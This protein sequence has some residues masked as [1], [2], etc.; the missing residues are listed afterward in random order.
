MFD[1][2]IMIENYKCF[3][4][5]AGFDKICRMNFIVGRN[6][7]G[8]SS[9]LDLA[10]FSCIGGESFG[11]Q[12]PIGKAEPVIKY[13]AHLTQR[14]IAQVF[15]SSM[16][17][18]FYYGTHLEYGMKLVG[19]RVEVSA[20]LKDGGVYRCISWADDADDDINPKLI[21]IPEDLKARLTALIDSPLRGK[22]FK[23]ILAERDVRPEIGG[24]EIK[25]NGDGTGVTDAIQQ[26]I[27]RSYRDSDLV[28][29]GMLRALNEIFSPDAHFTDIVCQMHDDNTWEIY[30]QEDSK[31]RVALSKSGS[32]LKTVLIVLAHLFLLPKVHANSLSDYVFA[33]EELENNMHPALLRRL[34]S[35][36]YRSAVENNYVCFF[37]THSSVLIDQFNKRKDSQI[38][39]VS[40]DGGSSYCSPATTFIHNK[41][42]LDDL[43][44]RA[45]DVLQSNGIIWVEGPSDRIYLNRWIELWSDGGLFEGTHY[46]VIFYGG[47]LLSHLSASIDGDDSGINLLLA[48][49]NAAILIDSDKEERTDSVNSTKERIL[50]EFLRADSFSWLTKGREIENYIPRALVEEYLNVSLPESMSEFDSLFSGLNKVQPDLGLKHARTKPLF[51]ENI[52]RRMTLENMKDSLDIDERM[53]ELCRR[54]RAWNK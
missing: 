30:I 18:G 26:F 51:A 13:Q 38:I 3:S 54:I 42:I 32:G 46:Q 25:I 45:S 15:S 37:T 19:K 20:T 27:N 28:E 11:L 17:G 23:R 40:H 9:L 7:S 4:D 33:F 24:S 10:A 49:R 43:D 29:K 5:Q 52:I 36:I 44:I 50:S 41:G 8:K 22:K 14:Q 48:N 31:G 12:V 53:Q 21:Q 6:N 2:S 35:Y 34:A 16:S 1:M 39:H 47:R